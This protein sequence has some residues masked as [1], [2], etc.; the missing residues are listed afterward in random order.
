MHWRNAEFTPF[1]QW[2]HSQECLRIFQN[3]VDGPYIPK[4]IHF[5]S[6]GYLYAVGRLEFLLDKESITTRETGADWQFF[7]EV[8]G[9]G[10]YGSYVRSRYNYG[11]GGLNLN[12][13]LV[14]WQHLSLFTYLGMHMDTNPQDFAPE[15]V[16]YSVDYGLRYDWPKIFL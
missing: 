1:V 6:R 12:L 11:T 3:S 16:L 8:H 13:D 9:Q 10:N 4:V 7:P 15:T 5:E 14:R 2:G